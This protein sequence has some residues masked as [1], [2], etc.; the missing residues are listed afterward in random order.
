MLILL[1]CNDLS[2]TKANVGSFIGKCEIDLCTVLDSRLRGNDEGGA[3][4]TIKKG[5]GNDEEEFEP[6]MTKKTRG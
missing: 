1:D 4:M 5:G 3:G 6:R 2:H